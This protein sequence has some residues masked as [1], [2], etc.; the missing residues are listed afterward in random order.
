MLS[1][2]PGLKEKIEN[3]DSTGNY[4]IGL[5]DG[6]SIHVSLKEYEELGRVGCIQKYYI[7]LGKY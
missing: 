6:Q 3:H 1:E 7:P 4:V 5:P 2:Y